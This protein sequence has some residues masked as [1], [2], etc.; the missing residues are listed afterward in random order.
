MIESPGAAKNTPQRGTENFGLR[1]SDFGF[2][3]TSSG[4]PPRGWE[5]NPKSEI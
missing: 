5:A 1:I 2:S 4:K 3:T